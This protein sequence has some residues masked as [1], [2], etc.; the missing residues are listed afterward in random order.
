[1]EILLALETIKGGI[2]ETFA[3]VPGGTE[4]TRP[5]NAWAISITHSS[6]LYKARWFTLVRTSQPARSVSVVIVIS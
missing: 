2:T 3:S 4:L 6:M 5:C 1:M